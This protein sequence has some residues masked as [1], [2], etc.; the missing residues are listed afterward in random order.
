MRDIAAHYHQLADDFAAT[1]AAVPEDR[2]SSPSPC[3]GWSA[4]DVVA[5]VVEAHGLF[6]GFVGRDLGDIP[7]VED[8]PLAAFDA[9]RRIVGA[10]LDDPDR[11]NATFQGSAGTTT[12]AEACGKY[13][14]G[15]V[16]L[17]RWDLGQATGQEITFPPE[18]IEWA[19][20]LIESYGDS[21]RRS[22]VYGEPLTPPPGADAQTRLLAFVGRKAW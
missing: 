17:H 14:L 13:L 11:A 22:D 19:H 10:D 18:E 21:S 3:E 12:F 6:L 16:L 8:D 5:H 20:K 15:D 7:S 9:A 4:R 2:W 1:V